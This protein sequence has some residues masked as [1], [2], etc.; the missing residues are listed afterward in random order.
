[1]IFF[2]F[3]PFDFGLDFIS[4]FLDSSDNIARKPYGEDH[5][6]TNPDKWNILFHESKSNKIIFLV[7]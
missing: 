4:C 1:M 3:E 5:T 6:K 7:G 2:I